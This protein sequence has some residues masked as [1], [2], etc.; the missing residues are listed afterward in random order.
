M[1]LLSECPP[2]IRQ[3]K[4][5][6]KGKRGPKRT[7]YQLMSSTDKTDYFTGHDTQGLEG[8]LGGTDYLRTNS[9]LEGSNLISP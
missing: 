4:D 8:V 6:L 5:D 9:N 7:T 3:I 1:F 2:R